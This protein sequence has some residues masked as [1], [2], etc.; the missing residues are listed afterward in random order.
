MLFHSENPELGPH[1]PQGSRRYCP[2][3]SFLGWA[4]PHSSTRHHGRPAP[5]S[6]CSIA[7]KRRHRRKHLMG[8]AT[9]S[10]DGDHG[11]R[12]ADM[13]LEQYTEVRDETERKRAQTRS[14]LIVTLSCGSLVCKS[15]VE[16]KVYRLRR[17]RTPGNLM[18]EPWFVL[19]VMRRNGIKG[20]G[21]VRM[22][23]H[24]ANPAV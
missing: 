24:P 11:G 10:E 3:S 12:E 20:S 21:A 13:V 19:K 14:S 5:A 16:C 23:P 6:Y 2:P 18:L 7:V 22:R 4:S 1:S 8:V 9:V 15:S 17:K